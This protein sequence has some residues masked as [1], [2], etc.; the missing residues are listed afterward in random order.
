MSTFRIPFGPQHPA[1]EESISFTFE[2]EGEKVVSVK[3]RLGYMH[4]GIEK[5]AEERT[6]AQNTHLVERVCGICS[7][8]HS[9][10]FSQ[11]VEEIIDIEIPARARY[12]RTVMAELERVQ[13]H[14]LWLGITAHEMGFQTLFMYTWRDREVVLN[15]VEAVTGKRVNYGINT[16]GG[17]RR[18]LTTELIKQISKGL[19][20]IEERTNYY[21]KICTSES[22]VLNRT[23][24]VG[25]LTQR[26]A[27][28]L[29]AVGPTIRASGIKRDVRAD[30]P[31][32]A[33]DEISFNVITYD[34]CDVASRLWVRIDEL[35]ES[36]NIINEALD[37]LPK[38]DVRANVPK[39]V[40]EGESLNRVE[41]PRGENA[42]YLRAD[43]TDRPFRLKI[44]A[45]T[46]A[47]I[48]ALCE[49]FV[50]M[51]IADI[52][53]VIAGIDPCIACAER[54]TFIDMEK[55]SR[56][57]WGREELRRFSQKWYR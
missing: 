35:F 26:D 50:D 57:I 25:I 24:D 14:L 6:Y 10:C 33:Y 27:L 18:N 47:N 7:Q 51:N 17:M 42:H 36:M 9:I 46:L 40:Q 15:I 1:L 48:L 38:G 22:T 28:K 20:I 21:K 52:P 30:D 43:G 16:I 12:I 32:A 49:M 5:L 54:I 56:W 3:P 34:G 37:N 45:P 39:N 53:V 8:A 31:Y 41:A 11:A 19:K 2:V 29:S 44:R 23:I 13:N 55:K 4:R